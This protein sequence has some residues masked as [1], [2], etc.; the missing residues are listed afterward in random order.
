MTPRSRCARSIAAAD[1]TMATVSP[2][3][4]A[5]GL[6]GLFFTYSRYLAPN[7]T[8]WNAPTP[9]RYGNCATFDFGSLGDGHCGMLLHP[10]ERA[11]FG[12]SEQHRGNPQTRRADCNRRTQPDDAAC[13]S[14]RT[15]WHSHERDHVMATARRLGLPA[16]W[17]AVFAR[18][19]REASRLVAAPLP[20]QPRRSN[21]S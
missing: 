20:T 3:L 9:V 10:G 2:G 16:L 4:S 12:K 15:G 6:I 17:P 13:E 21:P 5:L 11:D 19:N 1:A 8:R 7:P 18:L 14:R